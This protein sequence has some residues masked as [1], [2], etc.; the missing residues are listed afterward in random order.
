MRSNWILSRSTISLL[1]AKSAPWNETYT[2]VLRPIGK[3]IALYAKRVETQIPVLDQLCDCDLEKGD[4]DWVAPYGKG[5]TEDFIFT[6]HREVRGYLD[7]DASGELSF[8]HPLDGLQ[9]ASI[10]D[11]GEYSVFKW[12]RQL[13]KNGFEPKFQLRNAWFP[14]RVR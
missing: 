5:M 6:I 11:V 8:A 10:P 3:P 1:S 13:P 9:E 14:C 7:F 2:T 12:E 4:C